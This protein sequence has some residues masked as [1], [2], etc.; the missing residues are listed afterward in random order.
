MR[1]PAPARHLSYA[2]SPKPPII[3][4]HISTGSQPPSPAEAIMFCIIPAII[5]D[6]ILGTAL[7]AMATRKPPAKTPRRA[8]ITYLRFSELVPRIL[9]PLYFLRPL[10]HL[11]AGRH[12]HSGA[13]R[14]IARASA[15]SS[16]LYRL[17][18]RSESPCQVYLCVLSGRCHGVTNKEIISIRIGVEH[19]TMAGELS[20]CLRQLVRLGRLPADTGM[21]I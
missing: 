21:A 12:P 2:A 3:C 17:R 5:S 8:T 6:I 13:H 20:T 7:V 18:P 14:R 11:L 15:H 10:T 4:R 9:T 19:P 1:G 16:T